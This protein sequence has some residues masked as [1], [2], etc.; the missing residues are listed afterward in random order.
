MIAMKQ[1]LAGV[2]A[3]VLLIVG[4][5]AWAECA[6]VLWEEHR[7]STQDKPSW[8]VRGATE[9]KHEC[10]LRAAAETKS[11]ADFMKSN[12]LYEGVTVEGNS[13]RG[14]VPSFRKAELFS[15]ACLPD[16]VDPRPRTK[17]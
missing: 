17:E 13:V 6:W 8:L 15:F 12:S 14:L 4:T 10:T 16:T 2:V 3:A 9:T 11:F 5:E 7:I 1:V